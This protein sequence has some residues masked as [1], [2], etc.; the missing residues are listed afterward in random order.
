MSAC[1]CICLRL[2]VSVSVCL[3]WCPPV[4]ISVCLSVCACLC[5]SV[6]VC[7]CL[8]RSVSVRVSVPPLPFLSAQPALL[9]CFC[10]VLAWTVLSCPV[11]PRAVWS[12]LCV[13]LC[14]PLFFVF[15]ISLVGSQVLAFVLYFSS[16][17]F[18]FCF[19]SPSIH[20]ALSLSFAL[21]PS[22]TLLDFSNANGYNGQQL[23]LEG[24]TNATPPALSGKRGARMG[25]SQRC[26]KI[27]PARLPSDGPN[28]Q[29]SARSVSRSASKLERRCG[30][31]HNPKA[32]QT[33]MSSGLRQRRSPKVK[34]DCRL[35]ERLPLRAIHLRM[36]LFQEFRV[37]AVICLVTFL[38]ASL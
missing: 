14:V 19:R 21:P 10:L 38:C 17:F 22:F 37:H 33:L 16:S 35:V 3:C 1:V 5:L 12:C 7:A 26:S 15:C 20:P 34:D 13:G 4:S 29:P 9:V 31:S 8:G 2:S 30:A 6:L 11:L 28:L 25:D 32:R 24:S 36:I 18:L 23:A 27:A